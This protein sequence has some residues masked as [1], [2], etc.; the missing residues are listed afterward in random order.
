[1]AK[2]TE[3]I[4]DGCKNRAHAKGYCRRHYGQI[5]RKG[6]IDPDD[7]IQSREPSTT[8][9][10]DDDRMRAL[11]RELRK[12]ENM[13]RQVVGFEGRLKWRKE[14]E[15]VKKEIAHLTLDEPVAVGQ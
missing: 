9:R 4:V 15:A 6:R 1:M 13:Y 12:A 11:E 7:S 14:M 10:H 2:T 8:S 5:W 3:C